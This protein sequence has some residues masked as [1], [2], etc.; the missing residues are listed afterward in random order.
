MLH[1]ATRILCAIQS[2]SNLHPGSAIHQ[3]GRAMIRSVSRGCILPKWLRT[4]PLWALV[5]ADENVRV[6]MFDGQNI[7]GTMADD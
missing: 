5:E 1:D 6:V 4:M 7:D 2:K 3:V